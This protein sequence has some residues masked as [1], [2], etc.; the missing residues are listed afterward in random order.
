MKTIICVFL[1]AWLSACGQKLS[2][3]Y[4]DKYGVVEMTFSSSDKLRWNTMGFQT[5]LDYTVEG[6]DIKVQNPQGG[7]TL[8]FTLNKDG[9]ISGMGSTLRKKEK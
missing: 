7:A 8:I 6:D 2:G 4:T 3:T 1:L 5:E 9:S